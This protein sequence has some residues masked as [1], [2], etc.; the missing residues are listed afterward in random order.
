MKKCLSLFFLFSVALTMMSCGIDEPEN[1]NEPDTENP[2]N[3]VLPL[4]FLAGAKYLSPIF[5]GEAQLNRW[6]KS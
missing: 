3:P 6:L 5:H 2:L 4:N 1:L